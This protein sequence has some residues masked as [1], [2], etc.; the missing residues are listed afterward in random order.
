MAKVRGMSDSART[1]RV[2]HLYLQRLR[3]IHMALAAGM[4]LIGFLTYNLQEHPLSNFPPGD[5]TLIYLVPIAA[6][7]G[8]FFGLYLLNRL[9]KSLNSRQELSIRLSRYQT[10]SLL[11]YSCLEAPTLLALFAYIQQGYIFYA[12]IAACMLLYF[13]VQ[14]PTARK[15]LKK[16]PLTA[17]EMEILK[18]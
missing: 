14:M 17:R 11:Y 7:T 16:V 18:N 15:I 12:T 4:L 9:L 8:Y 3:I 10:A 6:L 2:F 5:S 1:D 13:C